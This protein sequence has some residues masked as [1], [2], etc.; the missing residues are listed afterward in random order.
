MSD[1][2]NT[3]PGYDVEAEGA[4]AADRWGAGCTPQR[5]E[6]ILKQFETGMHALATD[7]VEQVA[8]YVKDSGLP[9]QDAL[10]SIR[11]TGKAYQRLGPIS[12]EEAD[13]ELAA[14]KKDPEALA[15]YGNAQHPKHREVEQRYRDLLAIAH[16]AAGR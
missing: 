8:A 14:M 1:E 2:T 3:T 16:P 12:P 7:S 6:A 4:I 10:D 11:A 9:T 15:A 13:A 5:D